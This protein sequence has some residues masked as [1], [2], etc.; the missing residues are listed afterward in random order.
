M[1]MNKIPKY[2]DK[3]QKECLDKTKQNKKQGV[4]IQK[5]QSENT[6]HRR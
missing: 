2:Q 1:Q 5:G 6:A 4:H 3:D